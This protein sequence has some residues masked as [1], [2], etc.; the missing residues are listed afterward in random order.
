MKEGRGSGSPYGQ[1]MLLARMTVTRLK[2]AWSKKAAALKVMASRVHYD[3]PF[4]PREFSLLDGEEEY[5]GEG[6]VPE[7]EDLEPHIPFT[8]TSLLLEEDLGPRPS[9]I[10]ECQGSGQSITL[11]LSTLP[12]VGHKSALRA[13]GRDCSTHSL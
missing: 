9:L 8:M 4:C 13:S 10:G 2:T 11:P 5:D 6:Q 12:L 3:S 7:E 1:V